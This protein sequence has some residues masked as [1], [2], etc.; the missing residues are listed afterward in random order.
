LLAS[1]SFVRLHVRQNR[2]DLNC[3][4]VNT[5]AEVIYNSDFTFQLT[6]GTGVFNGSLVDPY[7]TQ[8]IHNEQG[9]PW[10]PNV[11][12]V[13]ISD[14]TSNPTWTIPTTPIGCSGDNCT[15]YLLPGG[16]ESTTPWPP[17]D[18]PDSPIVEIVDAPAVQLEFIQ[19]VDPSEQ[20][21]Q[22]DCDVIGDMDYLVAVEICLKKGQKY[23]NSFISRKGP[24]TQMVLLP[25]KPLIVLII[26]ANGTSADGSCLNYGNVSTIST[27]FTVYKRVA[28]TINSRSNMT[29]M[30]ISDLGSASQ[31]SDLDLTALKKVV[32]WL[33]DYKASDIPVTSSL[34]FRFWSST[35]D[36]TTPFWAIDPYRTFTGLLALP[37]WFF[38][39]N[40]YGNPDM[41]AASPDKM[42][43][44]LPREYTTIAHISR[45]YNKIKINPT[46]LTAY[47]LLT[48]LALA[49][50][51]IVILV[52]LIRQKPSPRTSSY[53]LIDFAG[54]T[55]QVVTG[56]VGGIRAKLV[57]L[58]GADDRRIRHGLKETKILLRATD[59]VEDQNEFYEQQ[60][61][62]HSSLV[63]VS[64]EIPQ[65]KQ[66]Q[67]G[68]TCE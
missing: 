68:M 61:H 58:T 23:P 53:P 39:A 32:N 20:F 6:A 5:E 65:L 37:M 54:K 46:M 27:T 51:W 57:K 44:Y 26:C 55:S 59:V 28:S 36:F 1:C 22:S 56:D 62:R 17:T 19:G 41:A 15:A 31:V 16:L 34:A 30:A 35:I 52:I 45:P 64:K 40:N 33:L 18:F 2:T 48:L 13:G 67:S 8:L 24:P 21:L 7:L 49:F 25:T 4:L 50:S 3:Y 42:V 29:I 11:L 60:G 10:I 38:Q 47:V 12:M 66:I 14:F 9:H 43:T 63:L